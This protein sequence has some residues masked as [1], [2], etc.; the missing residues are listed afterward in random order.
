MTPFLAVDVQYGGEF[1]GA[2]DP[3]TSLFD[4]PPIVEFAVGGVDLSINRTILIIWFMT[5]VAAG[6]FLAGFRGATIV[7]GKLQAACEMVIDFVRGIAEDIIGPGKDKGEKFVPL[8]TTFF[9]FVFFMN[10]AKLTPG[11]MLPPTSRIAVAGFLALTAWAV[12]VVVGIQN[13]GFFGYFKELAIPPGVP[14][15][16]LPILAPIEIISNLVLRPFTLGVRLFANMVAGHILVVI[17]L[18]TIHVFLFPRPGLPVGILALGL[19]PLVFAFELL[20]IGLQAYIFT[21]LTAVYISSSMES[22]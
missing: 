2:L 22:H 10:V 3:I 21:M 16:L 17:T 6:L 4:M 8:L 15:A 19:S 20:I 1:D 7:P 14:K 13:H 11:I 9:V 5:A 12:Y 18:V